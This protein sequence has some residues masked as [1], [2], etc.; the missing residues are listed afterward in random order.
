M[1]YSDAILKSLAYSDIFDFPLTK[2]ELWKFLISDKLIQK[3]LFEESLGKLI[4]K[5]VSNKNGYLFLSNREKIADR[6]KANVQE[7]EK[8]LQIAKKAASYLSYIPSILFIGLSGGLAMSD[9]EPS[10]DI[11]FFIITKK[12][13]L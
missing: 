3:R 5:Q 4:G 13:K 6:R 2:E 9:A 7:V 8:K 11:D 12:Q 1:G 10:D